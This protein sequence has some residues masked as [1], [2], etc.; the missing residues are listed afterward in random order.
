[1]IGR[2]YQ[3]AFVAIILLAAFYP[4]VLAGA[5]KI[6]DFTLVEALDRSQG[7]SLRS[8]FF[9]GSE[10]GSYY[11]PLLI[12]SYYLDESLFGALP[13]IMH[14]E[15]VVLHVLNA[16]L[17]YF[18]TRRLLA[19][20]ER[21]ASYVPLSAALLF[22]L[23]PLSSESVNWISGRTD[24]LAG[25][26]VLTSTLLLLLYKSNRQRI[27]LSMAFLSLLFA[28]LT[29]ET[30]LSFLPGALLIMYANEPDSPD[31]KGQHASFVQSSSTK[32]LLIAA[33]IVGVALA[34]IAFRSMAFAAN[35]SRIGLTLKCISDDW[36]HSMFVV[37][38]AFGFYMKKLVCPYP[39]NFAIMGIDPLYE[40]LAVP[41]VA[42]CVVIAIRRSLSS[43]LFTAGILMIAPA[44]IIAFG[45]I[46][47]TPYAERYMYMPSAFII[48][49]VLVYAKSSIDPKFVPVFRKAAL[50][51]FS[52]MLVLSF[53][54]S[55]VWSNDL[56]LCRDTV[57]KSPLARD[58]RITYGGLL[59]E[60]GTYDEALDQLKKARN[61]PHPVYDERIDLMTAGIYY[62]QGRLDEALSQAEHAVKQ[63]AEKSE[64][65][66]RSAIELLEEK[67]K[68]SKVPDE[69][70][71]IT[72]KLID[73][74]RKL[75][76]LKDDAQT[77]FRIGLLSGE[78]GQKEEAIKLLQMS[79]GRMDD[80]DPYKAVA[81]RALAN[82]REGKTKLW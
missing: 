2:R 65:A 80:T 11:R 30:A 58:I 29:K 57:E 39:L 28:V 34:F 64:R 48:V 32:N 10:N 54:R 16:I 70:A 8:I 61:I 49:A 26:F 62:K 14:L 51:C 46:A 37:L 5:S 72:R 59:A 79:I 69:K 77:L 20:D 53:Q 27:H 42:L 31:Q 1:M 21:N 43:A 13:G 82:N 78:L 33:G 73:Y 15:N 50:I 24:L 35:S 45:Q 19:T 6:D 7:W 52:V 67:K 81:R 40:V 18:L 44:F 63:T 75:Y 41:L 76:A 56:R 55:L 36:I 22:G 47:W 38:R 3:I 4:A 12:L 9:P 66:I 17:V 74:E 60:G 23:H 71:T 25:L 68:L